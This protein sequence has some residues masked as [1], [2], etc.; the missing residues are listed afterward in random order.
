MKVD[1]VP[2]DE[3]KDA[4]T[5]RLD[6]EY[7]GDVH[8]TIFGKKPSFSDDFPDE[9]T[10]LS[11]FEEKEKALAMKFAL[12]RLSMRG[13]TAHEL[14]KLLK[15]KLVTETNRQ[16]VID[17]CADYGYLH[18]EKWAEGYVRGQ[19][20]RKQGPAAIRKKLQEKGFTHETISTLLDEVG[21]DLQKEV[22]QKIL[23]TRY[24]NRDHSDPRERNKTIGALLRKGYSLDLIKD[25]LAGTVNDDF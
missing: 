19:V 16:A 14:G 12:N 7:W 13:Y 1:F 8:T 17:A 23:A 20:A 11:A 22:V 21:D 6:E 24:R 25:V 2:S 4:L 10:F 3:V 18:D 5:L 15:E 9:A